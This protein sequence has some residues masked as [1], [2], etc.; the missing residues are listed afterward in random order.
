MSKSVN[1]I[2]VQ[3]PTANGQGPHIGGQAIIEGVMMKGENKIC[4]S[5]RK[6]NKIIRKITKYSAPTSKI[7]KTPFIRGISSLYDMLVIGLKALTW[8]ANQQTESEEEKLSNKE[9]AG[10][11]FVALGM[12]IIIFVLVPYGLGKWLSGGSNILLNVFDAIFRVIIFAG[13]LYFI[14]KMKDVARVFQFHGAEHMAVHCFE[15][16]KKLTVENVMK[17]GTAHARC[18]TTFL[19][20]V[21]MV[22]IIVFSLIKADFWV[23]NVLLRIVLIPVIA[24][25]SYEILKFAGNHDNKFTRILSW[26]GMKVQ[27]MT[28][29]QPDA[30][31][32]EVAIDA[33][34]HVI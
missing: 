30:K 25:V 12:A 17:F 14:G 20:Y 6:K 22:S 21:I 34:K 28:T 27:S 7:L 31:Q 18:G 8:S 9:I 10:T 3:R 11:M 5:V 24:G 16:K 32:V 13:Y 33:I 2:V 19:V 29:R 26:P 15:H 23:W 4:C 1:P